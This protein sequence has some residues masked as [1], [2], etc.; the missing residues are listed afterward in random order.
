M[1]GA[2]IRFGEI[3]FISLFY[4]YYYYLFYYFCYY[5]TFVQLSVPNLILTPVNL[6]T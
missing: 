4:Y 2:L 3:F 1:L 5:Q 6:A